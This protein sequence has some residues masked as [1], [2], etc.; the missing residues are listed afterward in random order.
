MQRK[1]EEFVFI[2]P[3]CCRHTTSSIAFAN[4]EKNMGETDQWSFVAGGGNRLLTIFMSFI[5]YW[6]N[7]SVTIGLV[8]KVIVRKYFRGKVKRSLYYEFKF[9][10]T[11]VSLIVD[12]VR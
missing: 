4:V 11:F 10:I 9:K 8:V 7:Y 5:S 1:T 3:L 6:N 2:V 12:Y